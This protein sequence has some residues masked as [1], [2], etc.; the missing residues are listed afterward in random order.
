[1]RADRAA[2]TVSSHGF[3]SRTSSER[4]ADRSMKGLGRTRLCIHS[5]YSY[6]LLLHLYIAIIATHTC[7][8]Y[9]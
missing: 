6:N 1:M 9:K 8:S 4:G 3:K 2:C 7:Y 5:Y